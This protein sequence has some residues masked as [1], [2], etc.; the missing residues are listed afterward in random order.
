MNPET[1][2]ITP[3]PTPTTPS[4]QTTQ[5]Q[6]AQPAEPTV[7]PTYQPTAQPASQPVYQQ[8]APQPTYQQPVQATPTY[9]QQAPHDEAIATLIPYKNSPA[10]IGY[11][12]GV[13]GLIPFLGLP[14]SIAAVILGF[15]G[16]NK[17]KQNPQVK[18]KGHAIT[19]LILGI[20]ELVVFVAFIILTLVAD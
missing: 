14:L 17:N 7:Q 12:M 4:P 9:P 5:P 2:P 16:L 15:I 10:L 8:P 20:I 3:Q 11:Y 13:F 1:T 6:V 19:A 18:G